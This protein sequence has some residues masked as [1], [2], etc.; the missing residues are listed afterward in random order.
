MGKLEEKAR[1]QTES[2]R[3]RLILRIPSFSVSTRAN[4]PDHI[5]QIPLPHV[6]WV[7]NWM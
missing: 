1:E 3:F 4:L 2:I 7:E 5:L 6:V